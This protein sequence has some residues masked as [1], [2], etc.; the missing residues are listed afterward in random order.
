MARRKT[1]KRRNSTSIWQIILLLVLLIG[2]YYLERQG[3]FG[4]GSESP[5]IPPTSVATNPTTSSGAPNTSG[6]ALDSAITVYFTTPDLVYP[7]RA[8]SRRATTVEQAIIADIDAAQSSIEMA[9]FEYNL[10]S[11]ADA[12]QRAKERGV[13]VELAL[14]GENLEKEEM[15]EFAGQMERAGIP[16]HYEQSD[17]FLHSKFIIIDKKLVWMGS[18]NATVNDN[19]RNNNN[20]LRITI[21][22]IVENYQAEFNQMR[23]DLFSRKKS[24]L[25]PYP[26]IMYNGV[27][28]ENYFSPKD[29]PRNRIVEYLNNAR[30]SIRFMA[31]SFTDDA[32]KDAM[33]ERLNAGVTVQGVFEKRNANGVG[34]EFAPLQE[35]GVEVYE[36]GNCY[37]MHHKVIIIDDRIVITG[38]YNF[39][40]R[41]EDTNDENL[42]IIDDPAIAQQ[43][44]QEFDRVYN[45]ARNPTSCG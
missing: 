18:W 19:Y 40:G 41:A 37:T 8:S 3:W 20:L 9:V 45:Q 33:V 11:I 13:E 1:T 44:L 5:S 36:D 15:A 42:I 7:D 16:I 26:S 14:D 25:T 4:Q 43:F 39:T 31:F 10:F 21:P 6:G 17:A 12:L 32:I 27:T 24:S 38:S 23:Q 29:K 28:I 2:A 35:A 30:S 22:E 34:A